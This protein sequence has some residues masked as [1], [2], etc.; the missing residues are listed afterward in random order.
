[1]CEFAIWLCKLATLFSNSCLHIRS[2]CK[3]WF[4]TV[5]LLMS[6]DDPYSLTVYLF[7]QQQTGELISSVCVHI[8]WHNAQTLSREIGQS[9]GQAEC[10]DWR[11]LFCN[12]WVC[13]RAFNYLLKA[14]LPIHMCHRLCSTETWIKPVI[15][16]IC[17]P[18]HQCKALIRGGEEILCSSLKKRG[19]VQYV[20][21][22]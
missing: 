6:P 12:S 2:V 14:A 9:T 19:R 4:F 5:N 13:S 18:N 1:M 7:T 17:V 16:L 22:L 15:L 8:C 3:H 20:P 21:N 11:I 10:N